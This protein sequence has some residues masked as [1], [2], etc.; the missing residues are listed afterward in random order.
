LPNRLAVRCHD[1]RRYRGRKDRWR[2]HGATSAAIIGKGH[3]AFGLRRRPPYRFVR[4]GKRIVDLSV[5]RFVF[6]R[7]EIDQEFGTWIGIFMPA[8]WTVKPN[9]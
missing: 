1:A 2:D 6:G 3:D 4:L 8:Q 7:V 5:D 9:R